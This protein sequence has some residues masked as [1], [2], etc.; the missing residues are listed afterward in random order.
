M[1]ILTLLLLLLP[2]LS[3]RAPSR[4][5]WPSVSGITSVLRPV[6]TYCQLLLTFQTDVCIAWPSVT[7]FQQTDW[8]PPRAY[9]FRQRRCLV[10]LVCRSADSTTD[11]CSWNFWNGMDIW[12]C[13]NRLD[14]DTGSNLRSGRPARNCA[15]SSPVF[16]ILSPSDWAVQ[17]Q[18]KIVASHHT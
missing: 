17:L 15:K 11:K 10:T 1:V 16:D 13:C 18:C 6:S 2:R 8:L 12:T 5:D 3:S 14:F 4:P 7:H 9:H